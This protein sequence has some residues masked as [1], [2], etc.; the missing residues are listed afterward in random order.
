MRVN[1]ETKAVI[2]VKEF[3]KETCQNA[4]QEGNEQWRTL[5]G[6]PMEVKTACGETVGKKI[7]ASVNDGRKRKGSE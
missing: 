2:K 1:I 4:H 5:E 6:R 3:R 7:T